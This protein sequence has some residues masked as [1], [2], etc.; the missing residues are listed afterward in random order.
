[1]I[2]VDLDT[3]FNATE[4]LDILDA[5][6]D[7]ITQS[8]ANLGATQNRLSYT[9]N[10]LSKNVAASRVALGNIIDAD[11]ATEASDLAKTTIL[12]QTSLMVNKV[13]NDNRKAL[14]RLIE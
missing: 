13:S 11:L 1:M 5:A 4:S 14:L 12:Q 7:A 6:V 9:I 3:Q 8:Q 10:S 2:D